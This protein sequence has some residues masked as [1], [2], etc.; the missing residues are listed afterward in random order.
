MKRL[1]P[2]LAAAALA[3]APRPEPFARGYDVERYRIELRFDEGTHSFFGETRITLASLRDNFSTCELDAETFRVTSVKDERGRLRFEQ[4]SGKLAVHLRRPLRQGEK[5]VLTVAYRADKVRVDPTKFG[6]PPGYDLGLSFKDASPTHPRLINTLSFPEGARHWFPANDHPADKAASEIIATVR[7]GD[8]A[9]A[10]GRL[11]SVTETKA[12]T[13]FRWVQDKPHSTY[14][15]VLVAGPYVKVEDAHGALPVNYWVYPKDAADARRTF[16]QTTAAL[17]FFENEYGVP[18]PWDK[19]DQIT[20]PRFG[21]GAESTSATVIGDGQIHDE[22]AEQDFP[23]HWLVAHEAAHQWWGNL[24][25][26]SDWSETWINESF[27]TYGEYLYS[28]HSLGEDEGALNLMRKREAYFAEARTKYQRPIVWEDWKTPNQNFDRHTYE[29]GAAVLHMLRW[30]LGD[31]PFRKSVS[32]FLAKHAYATA[33]ARDFL[34]VL[35][36]TTGQSLEPFFE[37]WI[38]RAGH[39]VFDVRWEWIADRNLVRLTVEQKQSPRFDTPV[40][41]GITT[42]TGKRVHRMRI[43]AQP[44]QTFEIPC[45]SRPLLVRFDEGDHLLMELRF[46]KTTAELVFQLRN[47]DAMGRLWAARQLKSRESEAALRQSAREDRFWAVRRAALES[48]AGDLEFFRER[49][50]DL[51]SDV[52]AAALRRLA[53]FKP[54]AFLA[55]R[56]RN[57]DSYL[58]QAEALRG[59]GRCGDPSHL[60]LLREAAR[61]PSPRGVLQRAA[62]EA[63]QQLA[64]IAGRG[65]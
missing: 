29:K 32:R 13:R 53:D 54:C 42:S 65:Q 26:M 50:G 20:I 3:A 34:A 27:A 7:K 38:Y 43:A 8:H 1:L 11:A 19:Y 2:L 23:A 61:M 35:R 4:P 52:R 48:C 58:A 25:T 16:G 5:T 63:L 14:L 31:E 33:D 62:E 17:R 55:D 40:D 41:I 28:R 51:K 46:E 57:E 36:D 15:L 12:G 21:G 30:V 49:A 44:M 39:P 47:D 24:V 59:L 18:F 64:P 6:M 37:Q 45:D 22:R 9:V 10:N 56:F 60:A